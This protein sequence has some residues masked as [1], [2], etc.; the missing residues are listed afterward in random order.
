MIYLS[1][2]N[3]HKYWRF[4]AYPESVIKEWREEI[5]LR[6][7]QFAVSPL[8]EFDLDLHTETGELK[9]PHYHVI[10]AYPASTTFQNVKSLTVDT[11]H[12]TIPLV[13][14]NPKGAYDY[15]THKHD[16]DKFQY[17]PDYIEHYNGFD[18]EEISTLSEKDKAEMI[19]N[20]VKDIKDNDIKEYSELVD[21][22]INVGDY[23]K[24]NIVSTHTIFYNR[25]ITSRRCS[26]LL[27][28][29][30]YLSRVGDKNE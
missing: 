23:K 21:Y 10:L 4:I 13:C 24:L 18:I 3:K 27:Y 12:A 14:D 6:G 11:L 22:Y 1:S 20:I 29:E 28:D 17:N 26:S 19:V 25:Y 9:K 16:P 30:E 8:H 2:C 5:K 15:F 7:L